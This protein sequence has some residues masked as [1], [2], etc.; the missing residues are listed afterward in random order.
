M[1][2][3]FDERGNPFIVIR[4]Q[5]TKERLRGIEAL[6]AN[7]LAATATAGV[8][9]TS[10]G[11]R[12]MD[13]IVVSPYGEVTVT[14]DGATIMKE[15]KVEHQVAKLL[16]DLSKSMDNEIGDGTT[17][18]VVL[19]GALLE[20]ALPLL[21]RGLHP[22][23]IAEGFD[24]A[25]E[26]A[27]KRLQEI[28]ETLTFD[29]KDHTLLDEVCQTTLNSKIVSRF[30]NEL[31]SMAVEAVL[32]V[33]DLS[34][35]DVNLERIKIVGKIGGRLEDTELLHGLLID[36]T[37]SHSQMPRTVENAK[38]AILTCPFE[39][40]KPKTKYQVT[41]STADEYEQLHQQEQRYFTDQVDRLQAAGATAVMCQWGFDDEANSLLCS[42]N[43]PAVRWVL[44]GDVEKLAIVTGARIVQ[45]FEDIAPEKLGS[46]R[47]ISE[48][49]FGTTTEHMLLIEGATTLPCVTFLIRGGNKLMVAEAERSIHDAL[50]VA[51]NLIRDN[52]IV[53]GGGSAEVAAAIAVR[54]QAEADS[55]IRQYAMAAFADALEG[56]PQALAANSGLSPIQTVENLKK[57]QIQTGVTSLG[58]DAVFTGNNDMKVQKVIETLHG[59]TEQFRLATQIAKMVLKIDDVIEDIPL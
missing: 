27:V 25:C 45:R 28:S 33:A 1:S 8:I 46:A 20:S 50:C 49:S 16:C 47:K 42:R 3:A 2:L 51:R 32:T 24:H 23:R 52:R 44:G 37:W 41:I 18:V 17:S 15:M 59:K 40:P 22:L 57:Q 38:V 31:A 11:P 54:K 43:L 4:D 39:P 30:R 12:G 6:R 5:G 7:I 13:K 56:I 36:K 9:K 48:R 14:N 58:V 35:K 21:D 55:T 19:T 29:T 10:L 26:I 34:R 53:Y